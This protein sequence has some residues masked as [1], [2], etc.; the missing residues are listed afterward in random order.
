VN[1]DGTGLTRLTNNLVGDLLPVWSPDGTK[2]AFQRSTRN[3]DTEW[4]LFVMNADG[5][6]E[7]QL[8]SWPGESGIQWSP[9]SSLLLFDNNQCDGDP[10]TELY[11]MP[12]DGSR[13]EMV[14]DPDKEMNLTDW[15]SGK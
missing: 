7:R 12:I 15:R 11:A 8:T 5:T 13:A 2:I 3:S 4:D 14:F 1:A 10:K 9:D 6:G